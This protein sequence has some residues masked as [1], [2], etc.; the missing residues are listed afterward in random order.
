MIT[1][2]E[3]GKDLD[4]NSTKCE[5]TKVWNAIR[6]NCSHELKVKT[7]LGR[8]KIKGFVP[9][10]RKVEV[11]GNEYRNRELKSFI[12][13]LFFVRTTQKW[14]R[15]I[16]P[17]SIV[18]DLLYNIMEHTGNAWAVHNN[19]EAWSLRKTEENGNS[20]ILSRI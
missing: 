19:A 18:L 20:Y 8:L 7:E 6:V 12:N 5:G 3:E 2:Q 4:R 9:I 10:T 13:H 1:V 14:L 16:K 17:S 11:A 15:N